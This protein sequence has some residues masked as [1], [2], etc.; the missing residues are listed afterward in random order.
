M[1][2]TRKP[3]LLVMMGAAWIL[4]PAS[5]AA[6]AD[7]TPIEPLPSAP[8]PVPPAAPSDVAEAPANAQKS[9]SGLVSKILRPG[10]GTEHPGPDDRVTIDYTGWTPKG[11][12]FDS[13]AP[14]GEPSTL[15]LPQ[16]G[17]GWSE[18]V[19]LM[20]KGEKRR[21]W[22]PR[23]LVSGDGPP[24]RG[25]PD[26]P[27]VLD[28]ELVDFVKRPAPVTVTV[29]D[30]VE[31]AP[32]DAHRTVSGLAYRILR[33]G[34]GKEHP[35]AEST[36]QVHYSGWTPDGK[37]FDS[38]VQRGQ[39][40]TFSLDGVIKGWAEGLQLMVIGDKAR[41][42]IPAH[43]AYGDKPARPGAPAGALVFDVELLTIK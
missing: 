12:V 28:V 17:K 27:L 6:A 41:F 37:L 11:V 31:A 22:I 13:S 15:S 16:L 29:P 38:S 35:R 32:K 3:S 25:V 9:S 8:Q 39:P 36:V 43:L 19:Q 42:W 30:D 2:R 40:T 21:L 20:R 23:E 14:N 18:G 26:G 1:F 4:A 10:K 34:K 33:H 5:V 24:R 7:F